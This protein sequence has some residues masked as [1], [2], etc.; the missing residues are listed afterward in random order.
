MFESE[1]DYL[2]HHI[3]A[4]VRRVGDRFGSSALVG[5]TTSDPG[6]DEIVLSEYLDDLTSGWP[7]DESERGKLLMDRAL[8][9]ARGAIL[10]DR[11]VEMNG[12]QFFVPDKEQFA[13]RGE[14]YLRGLI[15]NAFRRVYEHD[16]DKRGRIDFD[17]VGVALL[18]G[19]D[20]QRVVYTLRR[21]EDDECIEGAGIVHEPGARMY[22]PTAKGL[23]EADRLSIP[24][25]APGLLVE[26]SVALVES[27][28]NKF[29]PELVVQLREQ[30]ARTYES[31]E[32]SDIEVRK[33]AQACHHILVEF[34]DLQVLWDNIR[35]D[36]PDKE[37]TR[38]RLRAVLKNKVASEKEQD[39]LAAL[40][41]YLVGWVAKFGD[42][43]QKYR[44]V[45][46]DANRRQAK[47]IVVY[48]YLLFADLIELLGL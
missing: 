7:G 17:D 31:K 28:L 10:L 34:L 25:R 3:R 22:K 37:L 15:L 42:F 43:V 39:L 44:H 11:L 18:E 45:A 19:I 9:R 27:R 46:P 12:Q 26:E 20:P 36:R 1:E 40:E 48:T 41:Q 4:D 6:Q 47:R 33:I 8:H 29:A 24:E 16:P 35:G 13:E 14:E 5:I 23:S 2:G 30:A 32:F 38:E 21:L